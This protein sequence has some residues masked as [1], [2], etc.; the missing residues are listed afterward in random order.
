MEVVSIGRSA[1]AKEDCAIGLAGRQLFV[2]ITLRGGWVWLYACSMNE[3][4]PQLIFNVGDTPSGWT[5]AR[6]FAQA[7]ERSG[8]KSLRER[9]VE[10]GEPGSANSLVIA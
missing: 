6:K 7:L 5:T 1:I 10:I 2:R 4:E 3:P 8:V 9:P